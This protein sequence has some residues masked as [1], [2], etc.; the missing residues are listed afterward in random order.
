MDYERFH[1]RCAIE[2]IADRAELARAVDVIRTRVV[3]YRPGARVSHFLVQPMVKGVGEALIGFR[4]DAQI[5][6]VVMLAA[7]GLYT[8]LYRDRS[9]RLAPVDREGACAMIEEVCAMRRLSG[10]RG[11]PRGDLEAL[12]DAIVAVSRL[13]SLNGP[14][15]LEA[16]VNPFLV[17]K[18]GEGGVAVDGLV[19]VASPQ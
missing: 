11:Q 10:P 18:E 4:R 13:A 3:A 19:R 2:A 1:L 17:L 9:L 6:P 8:E 16:E 12:A 5:G 15:I 7:G 14:L